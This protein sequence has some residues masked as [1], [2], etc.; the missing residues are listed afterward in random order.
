[1]EILKDAASASIYGA[2]AANGVVIITTKKGKAGKAQFTFN[3]YAGT[4]EPLKYLDV[5]D[6][7]EVYQLRKEA[8][9][10]AGNNIPEARALSSMGELTDNWQSLSASEPQQT[11]TDFEFYA[12]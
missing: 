2:Q 4:T 7:T 10:N 12:S 9:I 5:T 3:A 8:Y 11:E 6:A 1:M